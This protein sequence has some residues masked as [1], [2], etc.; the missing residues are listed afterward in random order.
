MSQPGTAQAQ[1][2]AEKLPNPDRSL[3][4][5]KPKVVFPSA[6]TLT[7]EQEE[8]LLLHAKK[9]LQELSDDL[10]RPTFECPHHEP[11]WNLKMLSDSIRTFMG[12]QY[13]AHLMY[14]GRVDW[15]ATD[16]DSIY[17]ES[18]LHLPL[19]RRIL[20]QQIAR[21]IGY[22]TGTEPWWSAYDVGS[23]DL[24]FATEL[25][26]YLRH[27]L[28]SEQDL[29]SDINTTIELTFIQG[30]QVTK[31]APHRQVD[32]YETVAKV[33]I[34]ENNE[35]IV[36][37]D[38]D[39]IF[40]SDTF[41]APDANTSTEPQ[42]PGTQ[43]VLPPKTPALVLQR[44][45]RTPQPPV[46]EDGKIV[47]K[48]V[49]IKR[50]LEQYSGPKAGNIFYLDF[51]CPLDA[52]SIDAADCCV[53]LY[54][55]TL[56][57]LAHQ[58]LQSGF[59]DSSAEEQVAHVSNLLHQLLPHTTTNAANADAT[60][61]AA[62]RPAYDPGSSTLGR[63]Q[64]EP[65]SQLAEFWMHYDVNGDGIME[66]IMMLCTRDCLVPLYY[67]YAA[68]MTNDGLRP[69]KA[70]V[71][72]KVAGRWHG[73]GQ[74]DVFAN[75]QEAADLMLNRWNFSQSSSARL[76]FTFPELTVEG[77]DNPNLKINW[78][79][80][81]RKE[82]KNT[83]AAEIIESVYLNDIKS[84]MLRELLE[85]IMQIAMNMSGVTNVNDGQAL[86]M[87]TAKLATG[88]RNLERSGM[89][90]FGKFLADIT[91]GIR[92][93]VIACMEVCLGMLDKPRAY[94]FFDGKVSRL[95][96]ISPDQVRNVKLDVRIELTRYRGEQEEAQ[97][98]RAIEIATTYYQQPLPIQIRLT[99]LY[100]QSLQTLQIR[101]VDEI[102]Q[103]FDLAAYQAEQAMLA[104]ASQAATQ[105][106]GNQSAPAPASA[107]ASAPAATPVD[108]AI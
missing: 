101:N 30:Q 56:I 7:T 94:R 6:L 37:M 76:D 104:A 91:P 68:N 71:V 3:S 5:D 96:A 80:Q 8:G 57:Q 20:S 48:A 73:Q 19:S 35:P 2:L 82:N 9:R 16:Q 62:A 67:D 105:P 47:F 52:E 49:K 72:N 42:P 11:K 103:P 102:I 54:D 41:I 86:G 39:Y 98:G 55:R 15:R 106:A 31:V 95:G 10:G 40:E 26:R 75:L 44:D 107:S 92:T 43:E 84:P 50:T 17:A 51:L 45:M 38:G 63:D 53:H 69:F 83:K 32:Y 90:L 87:D 18:N 58:Y 97:I 33:A 85:F 14:H 46:G 60:G 74:M 1:T 89:E 27:Q 78:G 29:T 21:A 13:F 59:R 24:E 64:M 70:T 88:V 93:I 77:K 100:R 79:Q 99:P 65:M 61:A 81:Y 4:G 66:S 36:A 28:H 108:A 25:E 12:R 23:E 34:D 22:I